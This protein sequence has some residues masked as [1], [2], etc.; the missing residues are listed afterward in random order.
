MRYKLYEVCFCCG[1][2]R[3]VDIDPLWMHYVI[4]RGLND[5]VTFCDE[6]GPTIYENMG[7]QEDLVNMQDLE[8]ACGRRPWLADHT[9]QL[10]LEDAA[11]NW[12]QEDGVKAVAD[13]SGVGPSG[14][15]KQL[16]KVKR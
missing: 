13:P 3:L 10:M 1:A 11:R 4:F 15:P 6:C 9:D 14:K 7:E 12:V 5:P 16:I 8:S 2:R